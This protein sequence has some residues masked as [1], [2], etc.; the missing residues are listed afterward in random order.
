MGQK[1]STFSAM[2]RLLKKFSSKARGEEKPEAYPLGCV[3]DFSDPNAAG[4][5]FQQPVGGAWCS[6]ASTSVSK[7]EGLGSIPSAP[8]MLNESVSWH[9]ER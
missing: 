8:A 2:R 9:T 6:T 4:R 7:T 3:E 1:V 5:F